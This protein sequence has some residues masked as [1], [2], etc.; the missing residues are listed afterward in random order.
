MAGR[1]TMTLQP[2]NT[3]SLHLSHQ[4]YKLEA[5]LATPSLKLN[6]ADMAPPTNYP[7]V[8]LF[9]YDCEQSP[10]SSRTSNRL[11]IQ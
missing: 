10:N 9:G 6:V 7:P 3:T 8:V 4:H 5:H 2:G 11:I 1:G